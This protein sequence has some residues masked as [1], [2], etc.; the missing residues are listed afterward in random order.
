MEV[1]RLGRVFGAEDGPDWMVSHAAYPTPVW[2]TDNHL[3][4]FVV[5][6]D[7]GNRGSVGWVD[8]DPQ[9][10]MRVIAVSDAPAL[11]PGALGTFYDRGIS[12]G[13]IHRQLDGALRLYFLGWN[14]SADV[15]FRNSIGLAIDPSGRGDRFE[16]AFEGP[17]IDRSRHDPFTLSYPYVTLPHFDGDRWHMFYGTSRGGGA[18][19]R[20]MRHALTEAWSP[21]GIDWCPTGEDVIPLE[22]GEYGL[23]RPWV[24]EASGARH[25]VFSIRR[26]QYTLGWSAWNPDTNTW[27]RKSP[28][29]LGPGA[30][31]DGEAAC[32]PAMIK[33]GD[34]TLLFYNGNG[35]GRTGFG[36]AEL[37]E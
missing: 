8:V 15:P 28:D 4:V 26:T 34:R 11:K 5:A 20:E 27:H 23:S 1:T 32:Y 36:V 30:G 21:D 3:R 13:S 35:Y 16:E 6:R 17:L 31:W 10:P 37:T 18:D 19:E 9:D 33:M 22:E 25:M 24:F 2:L 7:G 12:I 14:K 29:L